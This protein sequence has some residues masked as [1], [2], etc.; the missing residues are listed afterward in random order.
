MNLTASQKR[1]LEAMAA[2]R[3]KKP[4]V[5]S[6][7]M[8]RPLA[9]FPFCFIVALSFGLYLLD[10]QWGMLTIGMVIGAILR[11]V[12]HARFAS[13]AWPLTEEITDWAKVEALRRGEEPSQSPIPTRENGT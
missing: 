9:W 4:S 1:H 8:F 7:L 12:S 6:I 10:A 11:I 2:F 13:M 5:W 3:R